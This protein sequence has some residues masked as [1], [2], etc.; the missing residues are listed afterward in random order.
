MRR[1]I[2]A[3]IPAIALAVGF[4]CFAQNSDFNLNVHANSHATA[5]DIGLPVYPGATLFKDKDSDSSSADLGLV[6]NSFHFNVQ[7][8]SFVTTDPPKQVLEFY[9]RPL[10]KYGQV[11]EC[12][13]GQPVGPLTVTKSGLTCG[14]HKGGG[15]TVDGSDRDME[16]RAG[17]PEQFRIVGIDGAEAG[18]TKFGLVALVLPKDEEGK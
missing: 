10:A 8:V 12:N 1:F 11:L 15:M 14:D 5:K 17:R 2:L 4:A 6:L 13:H 18:K 16:L 7:A 3:A 9:R